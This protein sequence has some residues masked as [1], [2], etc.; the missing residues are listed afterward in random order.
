MSGKK[1]GRGLQLNGVRL[2]EVEVRKRRREG[3]R[4]RREERGREKWGERWEGEKMKVE[5]EKGGRREEKERKGGGREREE[6]G[7][8]EGRKGKGGGEGGGE[9]EEE[10]KEQ[11]D[12]KEE[13]EKEHLQ[14]SPSQKPRKKILLTLELAEDLLV[15]DK[16]GP[17]HAQCEDLQRKVFTLRTVGMVHGGYLQSHG[18]HSHLITKPPLVICTKLTPLANTLLTKIHCI[19]TL[20]NLPHLPN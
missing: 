3:I 10:E 5:R 6:G 15:A 16:S 14:T 4:G 17:L 11:K 20:T 13:R 1:E 9:G 19:Y 7:R 2:E 18:A 12:E 8:R